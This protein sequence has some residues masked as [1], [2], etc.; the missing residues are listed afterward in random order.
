VNQ[1]DSG[2]AGSAREA[3]RPRGSVC[4]V[5]VTFYPDA[6]ALRRAISAV[7]PQVESL[8]VVDNAT[9]DIERALG[10]ADV[11]LLRQRTNVGLATAQNVGISWAREHGC[12]HVLILDQDSVP[13]VGMVDELVRA[14]RELS[15]TGRV[16]AVG[17]R[18]RD[19]REDRDAPFV[20]VAFPMSHKLWCDATTRH[21][22]SDFLISSGALIP[23]AVL[24]DIGG[25]DDGLFIDNVDMEWSFRAR[26]RGYA[27][28]GVCGALM[29]HRLGDERQV[30]PGGREQVVHGPVRL[31]FIMR[32]RVALYRLRHTPR[33]W[34]AQ[35]LPRVVL[36]FLVFSVLVAPR[37]RN[38][39]YMLRGLADGVRGRSGPCPLETR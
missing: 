26:A 27:L 37:T 28:F 19:P 2:G 36:K 22:Q 13:A 14:W 25:M 20:R 6:E 35:D 31:Y 8:V 30:L 18:F 17:P 16:G 29:E 32:N 3:S 33:V 4:A 10:E 21:V 39:H 38:V 12:T 34:I 1:S 15:A 23:L 24:D 7:R 5:L 9:P 11:V